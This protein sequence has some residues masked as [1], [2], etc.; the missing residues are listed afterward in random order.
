M[1]KLIKGAWD[2]VTASF[3]AEY[4]Q[5][6]FVRKGEKLCW[7]NRSGKKVAPVEQYYDDFGDEVIANGAA[8]CDLYLLADVKNACDIWAEPY[9]SVENIGLCTPMIRQAVKAPMFNMDVNWRYFPKGTPL[10]KNAR[11]R[12]VCVP[13]GVFPLVPDGYAFIKQFRMSGT[14][15][16]LVPLADIRWEALPE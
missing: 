11:K 12:E 2:Y 16:L 5:L 8:L 10:V 15:Y 3:T 9:R 1:A 4:V 7:C 14:S 13:G 6:Y